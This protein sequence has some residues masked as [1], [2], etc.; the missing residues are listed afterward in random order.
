MAV[1]F[2]SNIDIEH[3]ATPTPIQRVLRVFG[4]HWDARDRRRGSRRRPKETTMSLH[5]T[6]PDAARGPHVEKAAT[7]APKRRRPLTTGQEVLFFG[8]TFAVAVVLQLLVI[9]KVANVISW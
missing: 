1:R 9:L 3:A 4:Y 5:E 8:I 7:P 2:A 6:M